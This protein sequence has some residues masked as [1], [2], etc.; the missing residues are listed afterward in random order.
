M[1]IQSNQQL[2]RY[3][4]KII[5]CSKQNVRKQITCRRP[6]NTNQVNRLQNIR[7]EIWKYKAV[8]KYKT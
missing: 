4:S 1:S 3:V 8:R 7:M 2:N 5:E 6:L